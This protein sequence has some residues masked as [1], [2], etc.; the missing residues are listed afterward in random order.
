VR[1]QAG[2][3]DSDPASYACAWSFSARDGLPALW[4]LLRPSSGAAAGRHDTDAGKSGSALGARPTA[5]RAGVARE[6]VDGQERVAQVLNRGRERSSVGDVTCALEHRSNA[7]ACP[8]FGNEQNLGHSRNSWL[9]YGNMGAACGNRAHDLRITRAPRKSSQRSISTD[10]TPHS[11]QR[12]QGPGRTR[13][14]SHGLS[15]DGSTMSSPSRMCT[16]RAGRPFTPRPWSLAYS[17]RAA[18]R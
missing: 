16:G 17:G 7:H 18:L 15:H 13:F 4:N 12:T 1:E 3:D 5:G 8:T 10:S 14:V 9:T 6:P 11:P 2:A